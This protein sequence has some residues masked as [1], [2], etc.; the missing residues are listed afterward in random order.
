MGLGNRK[1]TASF[2]PL[3]KFDA[4]FGRF[5]RCD[6]TQ[7]AGGNWVASNT[8]I[9]ESFEAVFD[10]PNIEVGWISFAAGGAPDFQMKPLGEDIGECPSDKHKEGF[11]LRLLLTGDAGDDVRELSS[12]SIALWNAV[13]ELHDA[14]ADDAVKHRGKLPVVGVAEIKQ[15][16]TT[17]ANH[18]PVFEILRWVPRPSDLAA[19]S[20]KAAA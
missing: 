1:S 6:R 9:T 7:D 8:D 15:V 3:V 20:R 2:T 5:N 13:D 12:T 14:Y 18:A 16:I 11:R 17:N 19:P 10:L 4:R